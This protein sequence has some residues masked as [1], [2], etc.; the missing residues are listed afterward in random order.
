MQ[1]KILCV[2]TEIQRQSTGVLCHYKQL[3]T[4]LCN[5]LSPGLLQHTHTASDAGISAE[6]DGVCTISKDSPR[7]TQ[8]SIPPGSVNEYQLRL[9]RQRYVWFIPLTDEC[10]PYLSTLEVWPR[11]GAMQIHVYLT[12]PLSIA[13]TGLTSR[14]LF[15]E[16]L[17]F[18]IF[19]FYFRSFIFFYLESLF[20]QLMIIITHM[21]FSNCSLDTSLLAMY[22]SRRCRRLCNK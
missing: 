18:A 5:L 11:Q 4:E 7:P 9:G 21:A 6:Y 2:F 16:S 3:V 10:V 22:Y 1:W 19:L 14:T 17:L 15:F 13:P 8:P 12:L 20:K